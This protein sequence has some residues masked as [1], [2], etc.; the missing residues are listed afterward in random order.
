MIC[1]FDPAADIP[2]ILAVSVVPMAHTNSGWAP[3]ISDKNAS[4]FNSLLAI[5]ISN[6]LFKTYF[7]SLDFIEY[8]LIFSRPYPF[9]VV[10]SLSV[11]SIRFLNNG[12]SVTNE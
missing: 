8:C 10:F 1:G 5:K 3:S 7:H 2:G 12:P 9:I 6:F 11:I 4:A